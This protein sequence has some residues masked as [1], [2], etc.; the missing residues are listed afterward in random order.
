MS[1]AVRVMGDVA[2][3]MAAAM[4]NVRPTV[5][6]PTSHGAIMRASMIGVTT[7]GATTIATPAN[8]GA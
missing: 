4:Q 6:M 2:M 3:R 5:T 8:Q 7:I 1:T